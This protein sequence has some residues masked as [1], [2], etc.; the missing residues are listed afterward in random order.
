MRVCLGLEQI[1]SPSATASKVDLAVVQA[2]FAV[3]P[4]LDRVRT[5]TKPGPVRRSRDFVALEFPGEPRAA[6]EKFRARA[7]P[8]TLM[9][10]A[11][12]K[13]AL[14]RPGRPVGIGLRR[15]DFLDA[16]LDPDLPALAL[17]VERERRARI[18]VQL[19]PLAAS[20]VGEEHKAALVDS[21]QENEPHG[22]L[23]IARRCR[24]GHRLIVG[25]SQAP[26]VIE[27]TDEL[28]NRV[29]AML[30]HGCNHAMP[31]RSIAMNRC[32]GDKTQAGGVWRRYWMRTILRQSDQEKLQR[33]V[34]R[35][36]ISEM[37]HEVS[38]GGS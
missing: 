32:A 10:R 26:G 3:R 5:H 17:P 11:C 21:L 38:A 33:L 15:G 20:G 12:R 35:A 7:K 23:S 37:A 1:T 28:R 27:P 19:A 34:E 2:M 22:C 16:S 14:A 29:V 18:A 6:R 24:K 4:K 8:G 30:R 36:E 13:L 31:V 9:R 25:N